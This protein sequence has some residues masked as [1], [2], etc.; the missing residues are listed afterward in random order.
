[1]SA[2]RCG[3][4]TPQ[5]QKRRWRDFLCA[6]A[7]ALVLALAPLLAYLPVAAIAGLLFLSREPRRCSPHP[8]IVA[9]SRGE[10]AVL[11]VTFAST[12]VLDLQFAILIGVLVSLCFSS[13][14]LRTRSCAA[15]SRSA[16]QRAQDDEIEDNLSNARS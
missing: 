16:T 12:L 1:V 10:S 9:T 13:T 6:A 4:T 3:L 5:A 2:N 7:G 8:Q 11:A 15:S 14:A